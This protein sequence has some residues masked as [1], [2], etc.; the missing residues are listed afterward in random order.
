MNICIT[1]GSEFLLLTFSLRI[2][3]KSGFNYC[4]FPTILAY[5]YSGLIYTIYKIS[6]KL[7]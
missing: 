5:P 7:I 1:L 6:T 2:L 3:L 4:F